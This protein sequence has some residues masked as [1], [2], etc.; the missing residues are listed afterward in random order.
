[1][2]YRLTVYVSSLIDLHSAKKKKD[3]KRAY[4]YI[5]MENQLQLLVVSFF[6]TFLFYGVAEW[7]VFSER[8]LI[9]FFFKD[10]EM[11]RSSKFLVVKIKVI[12]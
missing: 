6:A 7:N 12:Q 1:M 8:Y 3:Q 11:L 4:I 2:S 10:R 9:P 5:H